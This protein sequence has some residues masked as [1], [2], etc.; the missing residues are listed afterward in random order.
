M[1]VAVGHAS[2][3]GSIFVSKVL[4]KSG[5]FGFDAQDE[6]YGDRVE[7]GIIDPTKVVRVH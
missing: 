3:D 7:K 4:D 6:E 2:V 5:N 1:T